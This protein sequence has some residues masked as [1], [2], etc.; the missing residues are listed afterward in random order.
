MLVFY[1]VIMIKGI[2]NNKIS[3]KFVFDILNIINKNL[4]NIYVGGVLSFR[5]IRIRL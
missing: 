3:N 5:V 2:E 1:D 4:E